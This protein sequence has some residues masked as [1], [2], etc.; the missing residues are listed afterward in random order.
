M[1]IIAFISQKGGV[2][3]STLARALACEAQKNELSVKLADLDTQQG[4]STEWHRIRLDNGLNS[5]GSVEV[6]GKV[7][8]ALEVSE[9]YDLLILDGAPRASSASL[10]IAKEANLL[11][12]PSGASRDDLMP[13]ILLAHELVKNNIPRDKIH[14]ALTRVSTEAEIQDAK[15]FIEQSGHNTLDGYL[16][17][18]PS[19]RQAQNEGLSVTETRYSTLNKKSIQIIKSISDLL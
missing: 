14:I 18:K 15:D 19:Y 1:T 7:K 12:L 8:K 6:F 11:I 9:D 3:K 17:E 5:I 4:T 13:T 10:E 16:P 2:G